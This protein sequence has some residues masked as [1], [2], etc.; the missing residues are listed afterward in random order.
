MITKFSRN[1]N[2]SDFLGIKFGKNHYSFW[3][4]LSGIFLLERFLKKCLKFEIAQAVL[5][6]ASIFARHF[7]AHYRTEMKRITGNVKVHLPHFEP[8]KPIGF[9]DFSSTYPN[10]IP[11]SLLKI[12]KINELFDRGVSVE[13]VGIKEIYPAFSISITLFL[14]HLKQNSFY[15]HICYDPI[16]KQG[17]LL[18]THQNF[19]K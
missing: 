16:K 1:S 18:C 6:C 2:F 19:L 7:R 17:N 15:L 10:L 12:L 3:D 11:V 14:N 9:F 8:I 4:K 13:V 5:I